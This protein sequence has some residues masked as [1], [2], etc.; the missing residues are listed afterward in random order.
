MRITYAEA[1]RPNDRFLARPGPS[2]LRP[3]R[4]LPGLDRKYAVG[5]P[6]GRFWPIPTSSSACPHVGFQGV[7]RKWSTCGQIDANDPNVWSGR[8][9]QEFFVDPADSVLHQCIRPLVGVCCAPGRHGYQ[10]ARDVF[11]GQASTSRS[12]HQCSHAPGRPISILV[13]S[14]RRP[15]QVK[16]CLLGHR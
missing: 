8:A 6:I 7:N 5:G 14:S 1:H 13:S 4:R 9:L 2:G 3:R 12:G 15:R 16:H 11:S 10:R